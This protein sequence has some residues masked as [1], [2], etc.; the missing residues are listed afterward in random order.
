MEG[1][2]PNMT[3]SYCPN[4]ITNF[5]AHL[6]FPTAHLTTLERAALDHPAGTSYRHGHAQ[7]HTA[8]APLLQPETGERPG[9]RNP[10]RQ[11]SSPFAIAR[12]DSFL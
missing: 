4:P 3:L 10:G 7:L 5:S 12:K 6:W 1:I 11:T 2:L 8:A 9:E